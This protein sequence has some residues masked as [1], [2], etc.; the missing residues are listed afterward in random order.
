MATSARLED[1]IHEL[2]VTTI[3]ITITITSAR[4][5]DM[6]HELQ[7]TDNLPRTSPATDMIHMLQEALATE[8]AQLKILRDSMD[9]PSP[10]RERNS[11]SAT[12]QLPL[13]HVSF[14]SDKRTGAPLPLPNTLLFLVPHPSL[15]PP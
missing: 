14:P 9:A 7:V 12:C 3:T 10:S 15:T 13:C 2:Q 8:K 4:L 5:E 11:L 6:I 1:M